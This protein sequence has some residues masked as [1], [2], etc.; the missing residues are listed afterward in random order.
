[1]GRLYL[2][3]AA[4]LLTAT[5]VLASEPCVLPERCF[6]R[7]GHWVNVA[8]LGV[9][10]DLMYVR[11]AFFSAEPA[12][13]RGAVCWVTGCVGRKLLVAERMLRERGYRLVV[14]DGYRPFRVTVDM[15]N[16]GVANGA[17][18]RLLAPPPLGSAHNKGAAVDVSLLSVAGNVVPLMPSKVDDLSASGVKK[19]DTE[20]SAT[21]AFCMKE[22]GFFRHPLEWWHFSCLEC[23]KIEKIYDF[24]P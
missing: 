13:R 5:V 20:A 1:M 3:W 6:R 9:A 23:E 16:W 21:L 11:P 22:A 10:T 17:D 12:Y 19:C 4:L 2:I 8:K 14:H 7:P 18:L 24:V 15:W